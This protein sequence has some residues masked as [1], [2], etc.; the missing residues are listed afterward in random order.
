[1]LQYYIGDLLVITWIGI[2][3]H[4]DA[5]LKSKPFSLSYGVTSIGISVL[6]RDHELRVRIIVR[7]VGFKKARFGW[8]RL[9]R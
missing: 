2:F 6:M 4:L 3:K 8:S 1:M 7:I 9:R 5:S